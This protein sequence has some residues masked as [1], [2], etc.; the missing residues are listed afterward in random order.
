MK[1][2]DIISENKTN[3][4]LRDMAI[5]TAA[6]A[7]EPTATKI[8]SWAASKLG[9]PVAKNASLGKSL[10][11]VYTGLGK[12]VAAPVTATMKWTGRVLTVLKFYGLYQM[13][14]DYRDAIGRGEAELKAGRWTQE[15]FDLYH[16]NQMSTLISQIALSTTFFMALKIA[17]GWSLMVMALKYSRQP[18]AQ[19][20]GTTLGTMAKG[21]QVALIGYLND[22]EVR[23]TIADFAANGIIDNTIGDMGIAASEKMQELLGRAEKKGRGE[24]DTDTKT[25]TD[26]NTAD[27]KTDTGT[28]TKPATAT[29]TPND[30]FKGID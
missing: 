8:A 9:K 25:D 13:A 27:T 21:T 17:S 26:S 30:K 4:G 18:L 6:K 20:V 16:R 11:N 5:K 28:K 24:A 10:G 2:Y 7:L 12:N 14:K 1:I 15:Q 22:K 29:D 19:A 3:E 23:N